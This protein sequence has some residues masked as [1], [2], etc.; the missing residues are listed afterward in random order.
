MRLSLAMAALME[1]YLAVSEAEAV[2]L[3][4]VAAMADGAQLPGP[5][6][7]SVLARRVPSGM[8]AAYAGVDNE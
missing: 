2:Q 8:A 1:R 3:T 6:Q 4:M 5:H 7:R